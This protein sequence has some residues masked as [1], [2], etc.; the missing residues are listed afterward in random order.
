[1]QS[2]RTLLDQHLVPAHKYPKP[3]QP[4]HKI[5][6][7]LV[8]LSDLPCFLRVCPV[9]SSA[10]IS[11]ASDLLYWLFCAIQVST[12]MSAP[13]RGHSYSPQL[14][15]LLSF[16]C[17]TTLFHTL[18]YKHLASLFSV[19][20]FNNDFWKNVPRFFKALEDVRSEDVSGL[21]WSSPALTLSPS[22]PHWSY[23][24]SASSSEH[25]VSDPLDISLL[26]LKLSSFSD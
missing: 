6:L 19:C 3:H 15:S 12:Q 22:Q 13:Q 21:T 4:V 17:P 18:D 9:Y 8:G 20:L 10:C 7:T 16:L 26:L 5:H 2:L 14:L 25:A 24:S 11:H 1:M 23:S